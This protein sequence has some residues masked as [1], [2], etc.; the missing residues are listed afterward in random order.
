MERTKGKITKERRK[1]RK[2]NWKA[3]REKRK[4]TLQGKKNWKENRE[5]RKEKTLQEKKKKS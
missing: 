4:R 5:K 2:K 3:R 1:E